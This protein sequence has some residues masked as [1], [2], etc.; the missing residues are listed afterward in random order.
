MPI[1]E[2]YQQ[3]PEQSSEASAALVSQNGH[4]A[5]WEARGSIAAVRNTIPWQ[6][7]R[8]LVVDAVSSPHSKTAY[9]SAIDRFLEW[10][11]A[12]LPAPLSKATVQRY[13]A[14]LEA[15]GLAPSSINVQL[16][17]L[18]KLAVE[19][20]DNG[21]LDRRT[22]QAISSIKGA[23]AHGRRIGNWLSRE[24]AQELLD[25]PDR[26]RLKG[27]RDVALLAV[28][29]GAGLRRSEAVALRV[30]DIQQREGRW[31]IV[32]LIGKGGRVR[33]VPIASW[34]KHAIDCWLEAGSITEGHVFRAINR[35]G[36]ISRA[37]MTGSGV[38]RVLATYTDAVR[39]HDLRRSFAQLA[40]K[41][42][43]SIEQIQL[44]LGHA[45]VQTTE[46]YLGTQ[47]DLIDSPSDRI[48]LRA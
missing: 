1:I 9:G 38:Y 2:T 28:L 43:C 18:R 22:A 48:K 14:T 3:D 36:R 47:L 12:E 15:G 7:V 31:V 33:S 29:L 6:H 34:L 40:R 16:A 37:S 11:Q 13:R 41:A 30:D 42:S 26:D 17:A 19:A 5:N 20:A 32:D 4:A 21:L 24:A 27:V 35:G 44:S 45:S 10:W 25:T 8:R 23:K 46:R 39:P